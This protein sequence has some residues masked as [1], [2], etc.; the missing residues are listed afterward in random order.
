MKPG[1]LLT[2]IALASLAGTSGTLYSVHQHRGVEIA[3]LRTE[4]A[5]LRREISRRHT[6]AARAHSAPLPSRP[7]APLA[8][9]AQERPGAEPVSTADYREQGNAE[10]V[11][12]LQTFAWAGDRGDA[13]R[14]QQMIA[15][16]EPA[17]QKALAFYRGLPAEVRSKLTS[18]EA[19]AAAEL[20]AD[21][22][23]HPFPRSHILERAASVEA[24]STDRVNVRLI[25][26]VREHNTFQRTSQ[27]WKFVITEKMV[28]RFLE[29]HSQPTTR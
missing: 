20:T 23:K 25:G 24:E 18:V 2:S 15:F 12:A 10:P 11:A 29:A 26:S 13:E 16:D 22:I 14:V 5:D 19:L 4:N 27:G 7:T 6:E 21:M 28:D 17:R 3:R 1:L 9:E 8:P